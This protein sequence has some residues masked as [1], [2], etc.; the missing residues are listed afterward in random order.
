MAWA[1]K[2]PRTRP[3][4]HERLEVYQASIQFLA[5]ARALSKQWPTGRGGTAD[6]ILRAATS[7]A[8]NIAEGA[9]EFSGP[10]K[11]RFYRMARRS[12]TECAA[13][14]DVGRVLGLPDTHEIQPGKELLT[15]IVAMLIPMARRH[16]GRPV[17]P[18]SRAV[19][20]SEG[21]DADPDPGW[22]TVRGRA[23]ARVHLRRERRDHPDFATVTE[24]A[25]P[26]HD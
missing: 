2:E 10:D 23:G 7:I 4:D 22:G 16:E 8:L 6:Q 14:L 24:S 13:V 1:R 5:W 20:P 3:L 11:A 26:G 25:I 17:A 19:A 12:A 21:R 9:G 18:R 15:R